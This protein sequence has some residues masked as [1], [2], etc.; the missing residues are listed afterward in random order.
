M[1]SRDAL[2]T[3][4]AIGVAYARDGYE[5]VPAPRGVKK[6]DNPPRRN[7][8]FTSPGWCALLR[9]H[10]RARWV[11]DVVKHATSRPMRK[12]ADPTKASPR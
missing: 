12:T 4:V 3:A 6:M 9:S 1:R 8:W 5:Y 10:K 11:R 2:L 7:G